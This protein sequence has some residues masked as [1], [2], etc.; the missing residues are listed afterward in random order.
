LGLK[1]Y[2][3]HS[4]K[5]C[6]HVYM[7]KRFKYSVCFY[8]FSI[9]SWCGGFLGVF[10]HLISCSLENIM[11]LVII[12]ISNYII[13]AFINTHAFDLVSHHVKVYVS[14]YNQ[15]VVTYPVHAL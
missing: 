6:G 5:V 2:M 14:S 7:H 12:F 10:F 15:I 1:K 3:F 9:N 13:N 4:R 11:F 8:D